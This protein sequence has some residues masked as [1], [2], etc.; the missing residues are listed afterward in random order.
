LRER[1]NRARARSFWAC[2]ACHAALAALVRPRADV[3]LAEQG[4][5]LVSRD[6]WPMRGGCR[7]GGAWGLR[8]RSPYYCRQRVIRR[9]QAA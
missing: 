7:E 9:P 2:S 6:Q 8:R 4:L 3:A 5:R 1:V